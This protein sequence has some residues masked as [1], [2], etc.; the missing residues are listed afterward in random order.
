MAGQSRERQDLRISQKREEKEIRHAGRRRRR[1]ETPCLRR[2]ED[3]KAEP[4]CEGARRGPPS[5]SR[6]AKVEYSI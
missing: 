6:A 5:G 1:G 4:A 2:V 3:R